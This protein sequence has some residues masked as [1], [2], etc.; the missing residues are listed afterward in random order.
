MRRI[1]FLILL[2]LL[3]TTDS[4][5]QQS[6]KSRKQG[7]IEFEKTSID[8]GFFPVTSPKQVATFKFTNKGNGKLVIN[9][10]RTTCGC[11]VA[12]YPKN[13]IKPGGK[14]EISVVYDGKGRL[15]GKFSKAITVY[16][17]KGKTSTR[18]TISG[19]MYEG[20]IP[21]QQFDNPD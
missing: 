19:N 13:Y 18:L 17:D 20:E 7:V 9:K 1:T 8:F 15:K 12:N 5:A 16:T 6:G 11:T 2:T 3:F 21:L 10:V 14:G 4:Y